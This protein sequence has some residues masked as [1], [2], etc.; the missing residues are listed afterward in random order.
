MLKP[1]INEVLEKIDNRYYLVGTVAKRSRAII[2]GAE[3]LIP[4]GDREKAVSIA[5][6]EVTEGLITYRKLTDEEIELEEAKH[7]EEQHQHLREED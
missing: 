6:R 7:Y 5:T 4:V 3:P 2:D 1:S